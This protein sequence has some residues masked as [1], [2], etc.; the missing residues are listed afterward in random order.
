MPPRT[1]QPLD[2]SAVLS[3]TWTPP[4]PSVGRRSDGVGLLYPGKVHTGSGETESL[5]TW[6]ALSVAV[7]ELVAGND[8][9]YV[10]FEDDEGGIV[11]RLLA[12]QVSAKVISERFHY[13]RPTEALGAG[14]HLDDLTAAVQDTSATLAVVDGITEAMTLHGLNMLDNRDVATFGRILPRRV[15]AM[16]PAVL[17]LDHVVKSTDNRG[18][19]ALGAVHKLNG[20]D[21][22]AL[23]L[24]NRTAGGIGRTGRSTV[25]IAKDRPGQLRKHALP[26]SGGMFWLGDLVLTSHDEAFAEVTVDPPERSASEGGRPTVVMAKIAAA[27]TEHSEMSGRQIQAVVKGNARVV[28]D[29]LALLQVEGYVSNKSPHTLLRPYSEDVTE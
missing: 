21:G 23:V 28:R 6:L 3:G 20:L 8:V 16:G 5:K 29:A 25:R 17:C 11:G 24:E 2:L 26:S 4:E 19:Y 10:D 12:L 22:A 15:A 14:V 27:L 18:R 13:L 9:V 1:W 7:D